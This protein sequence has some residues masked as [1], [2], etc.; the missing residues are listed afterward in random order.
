MPLTFLLIYFGDTF[1]RIAFE[2]GKFIGESTEITFE[3]L[4]FY[5]VSLIFYSTYSVLN[6]IFYSLNFVKMLLLITV[7]GI[8]LK[9]IMN[10]ILVKELQQYGLALSTSISYFFFF[11]V[12]YIIL[13]SKLKIKNK[14]VFLKEFFVCLIN[15]LMTVVLVKILADLFYSKGT[16][17]DILS[18]ILFIMI[19][20]INLIVIKH[21]A[22]RTFSGVFQKFLPMNSLS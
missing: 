4:K 14:Y 19:Y 20:S 7:T 1:L 12:S 17:N 11:S 6:K 21:Q 5:A 9:L 3:A 2:R 18:I 13:G 16:S 8:L 22:V 15:A 10:F